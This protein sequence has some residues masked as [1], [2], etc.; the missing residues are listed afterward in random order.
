MKSTKLP[1]RCSLCTVE[2]KMIKIL[3]DWTSRFSNYSKKQNLFRAISQFKIAQC[4]TTH[5]TTHQLCTHPSGQWLYIVGS[6]NLDGGKLFVNR[7]NLVVTRK[8]R[9]PYCDYKIG[10]LLFFLQSCM[11]GK[12]KIVNKFLS[13][14]FSGLNLER[15]ITQYRD[16]IYPYA[17]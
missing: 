17:V 7:A 14:L 10:L 4:H 1:F 16:K 13:D 8:H 6:S 2:V 12:Y 3:Q 9:T 15:L 5:D 11:V